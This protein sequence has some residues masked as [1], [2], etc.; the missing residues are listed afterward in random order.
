[1]QQDADR[2]FATLDTNHDGEIDPDEIIAL[3]DGSRAGSISVGDRDDGRGR[4]QRGSRSESPGSFSRQLRLNSRAPAGLDC[5]TCRNPSS[6][7]NSNFN[8]GVSVAE[9]RQAAGQRFLALDLDHK[10]YLTLPALEVIRPAPPAAPNKPNR[11]DSGD[12]TAH[13]VP[14][15]G[16]EFHGQAFESV[17][18]H[19]LAGEP[20]RSR[21]VRGEVEQVLFLLARRRQLAKSSGVD[22]HM[23]GRA[24]HHALRTRPRAAAARPRRRRAAAARRRLDFLVERSVRPEETAPGSRAKLLLRARGRFDPPAARRPVPPRRCSGR[25]RGGSTSAPRDR[26]SPIARSTWLGRPDP[27]AQADP[28]EKAMSRRSAISRAASRPSRRMLRLP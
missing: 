22:D 12:L 16:R 23:A 27:L 9:F 3:R 6:P 7:Q 2:F 17:G 4:D 26:S 18:Q 1:M 14:R 8:R 19:D 24:G 20:R 11:N 10:G 25:S 15:L 13:P 28:S 21:R 5:S